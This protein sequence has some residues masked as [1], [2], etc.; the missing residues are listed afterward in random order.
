MIHLK[1]YQNILSLNYLTVKKLKAQ[2][3]QLIFYRYL[4][5]LMGT[6]IQDQSVLKIINAKLNT[7]ET[8]SI[9]GLIIIT[10]ILETE[11]W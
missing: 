1:F 11:F 10:D 6:I 9:S 5:F 8:P 3:E 2:Q 4:V 7:K